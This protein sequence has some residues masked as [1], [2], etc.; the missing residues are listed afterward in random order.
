MVELTALS[1][2]IDRANA[3]FKFCVSHGSAT[4]FF[5]GGKKYYIYFVDSLSLYPSVKKIK[6]GQ[7]L[8]KLLQKCYST[9]FEA[10]CIIFRLAVDIH[11]YIHIHRCLSYIH[12]RLCT[13]Y[14]RK[15][16]M[17]LLVI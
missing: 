17:V 13:E 7:Q 8:M 6:I 12:V 14:I 10:Q 2:R 11:G 9:L 4:R 15:A 1:S 16:Q 3:F 5:R